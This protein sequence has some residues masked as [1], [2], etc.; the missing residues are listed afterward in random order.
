MRK[1]D[2]E[3]RWTGKD[4][5]SSRVAERLLR[6]VGVAIGSMQRDQP[7][8]LVVQPPGVEISVAK[9]RNLSRRDRET[10]DGTLEY[11]GDPRTGHALV[12]AKTRRLREVI[13]AM[14]IEGPP[15][16]YRKETS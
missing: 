5:G 2:L 7:R 3:I 9:W 1:P 12:F 10:I 8:G 14:S 11:D 6:D 15:G 13:A 4:F 16:V